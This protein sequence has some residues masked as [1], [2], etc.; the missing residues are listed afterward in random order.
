MNTLQDHLG[1]WSFTRL[2]GTVKQW[3]L[4]PTTP[5]KSLEQEYEISWS[6]FTTPDSNRRI[7]DRRC[8]YTDAVDALVRART[9]HDG[10]YK[11]LQPYYTENNIPALV[12]TSSYITWDDV[13]NARAKQAEADLDPSGFTWG[14]WLSGE[15]FP[16]T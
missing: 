15:D 3:I 6:V 4:Q 5:E 11:L 16:N 2:D 1:V 13:L 7:Q 12:P 9:K 14:A 10:G 8:I